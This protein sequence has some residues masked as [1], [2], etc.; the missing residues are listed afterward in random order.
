MLDKINTTQYCHRKDFKIK[1]R[2]RRKKVYIG[3]VQTLNDLSEYAFVKLTEEEKLYF[4]IEWELGKNL[5]LIKKYVFTQPWKF[6]LQVKPNLITK[7]RI[8]DPLL[9][10]EKSEIE[11]YLY[12]RDLFPK[13]IRLTSGYYQYR[14]RW[15]PKDKAKYKYVLKPISIETEEKVNKI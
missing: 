5:R 12:K 7:I 14:N 15:N 13:M 11:N 10:Q 9:I 6:V 3:R 8:I 1:R 4:K 2:R